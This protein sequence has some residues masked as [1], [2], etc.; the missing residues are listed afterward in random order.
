[1]AQHNE[2]GKKGEEI[3]VAHLAKNGF[4]IRDVNWRF[5]KEEIDIVAEKDGF[6]IFVEVKTRTSEYF[7]TPAS[8][9]TMKKQ[10]SVIN[11]ADEYIKSKELNNESRFDVIFIIHNSKYTKIEH[12][13][14]AF[15]PTV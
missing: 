14:S 3:A 5:R 4:K 9:V 13:E 8:T 2:L 11:A 7:E 6:I 1:M 12:L 10:K 15:Y